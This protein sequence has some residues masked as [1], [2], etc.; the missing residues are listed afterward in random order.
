M[1]RVVLKEWELSDPLPIDKDEIPALRRRLRD[2]AEVVY[3]LDGAKLKARSH[4]GYIPVDEDLQ[5]IVMPKIENFE[6]FFY[7]LERA[8]MTPKVWTDYTVFADLDESERQDA[9]LFLV[10]VLL[11]KLRLLKRDGF[12]RKAL[13]RSETRVTIKGKI[14][15]TNT[16]RQC[17]IRGKPHQVHCAY[18]DP[19]VDTV[20]NRF[21]K[22]TLWRLIHTGLPRDLKRE[23]RAFWRIFA[24]VPFDPTER[25]LTEIER[26]IRRRR[27]PSS[28]S[29]Y[30]DILSLC[31]LIIAN[32][33]VIVKAGEDVRLSAFAIK[34]DDMFERYIRNILSE[35]LHP[36]FSVLDG[37]RERRKLFADADEPSI[38]PDIMVYETLKCLVVADTKY[39]EK[40]LPSANDW[41]Q[42]IA[43]TLALDVPIGVLI[44]S[45][46]EPKPPQPFHIGDKTMWVYYFPLQQPKEQEAALV[47]FLRQRAEEASSM[48]ATVQGG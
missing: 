38:T 1:T 47:Q 33:T 6:D 41:Y 5:L 48:W 31:F 4:V 15:L 8:G 16:V 23:L 18:F 7:V 13:P 39:K 14:E 21:I 28:R 37:N 3:E 25:Y 35:A 44:F 46:S 12:Y 34:M 36:D 43:Y 27:L 29:Y 10:R 30:I 9:P 2:L 20:E 22:Y 40:D 17:L 24:S 19:T 11:H 26:I 42:A 45:A 32:S